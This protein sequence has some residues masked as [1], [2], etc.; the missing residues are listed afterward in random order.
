MIHASAH[1]DPTAVIG[2][3]VH[4]G[5]NCV[6]EAGVVLGEGCRL[7][8]NVTIGPRTRCGARNEFYPGAI[9]GMPPQDLK[10]RGGDTCV[11]MGEDNVYREFVTVHAGTEVAGGVTRIGSHNRFL[12]GVH[13]AHDCVIGSDCILSNQVQLAGHVHLEDKV[14]MGGVSAVHH[15]TTLG[16][17]A[18]VGGLSR[19]IA[20]VPPYMIVEGNPGRVRGYNQT[21]LRRWK[22]PEDRIQVLKQAYRTVFGSRAERSGAPILQRLSELEARYPEHPEVRHLCHSMRL[23][24]EGGVYGRRLEIHRRDSDADRRAFYEKGIK[25]EPGH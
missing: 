21:G 15:F 25:A 13:I 4:I 12:V 24:L 11:E 19:I 22:L 3:D 2:R 16:T 1:I 6:V 8:N 9:I 18:F 14:T 10:Y 20:D 5:P 17:L 23:S 7:H